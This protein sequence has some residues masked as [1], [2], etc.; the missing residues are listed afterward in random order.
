MVTLE[1]ME[2]DA[3]FAGKIYL[4]SPVSQPVNVIFDTGS[5][6]LAVTSNLCDD[7]TAKGFEF[8]KFNANTNKYE[9]RSNLS[10][11][12]GSQAYDLGKSKSKK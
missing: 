5:E 8:K 3:V 4:G 9:E 11:R 6:H 2:N 10:N 1:N 12:C 7:K